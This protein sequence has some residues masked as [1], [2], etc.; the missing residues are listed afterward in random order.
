[1]NDPRR[2]L[3]LLAVVTL[4]SLGVVL[5]EVLNIGMAAAWAGDTETVGEAIVVLMLI[6]LAAVVGNLV[7]GR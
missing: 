2:L 7:R 1:M 6:V 5:V 3:V 4:V